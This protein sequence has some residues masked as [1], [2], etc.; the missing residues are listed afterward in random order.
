MQSVKN[1]LIKYGEHKMLSKI[2]QQWEMIY[3]IVLMIK[4]INAKIL[5]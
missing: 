4:L 5:C 3:D 2:H 1:F